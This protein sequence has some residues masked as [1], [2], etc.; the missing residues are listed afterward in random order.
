MKYRIESDALGDIRVPED[1][2]YGAQTQRAVENFRISGLKLQDDFIKALAIIKKN[3]A[4]ANLELG[5]IEKQVAELIVAAAD[6]VMEGRHDDQFVV[7]VFQTGSGTSTNMNMNE[8]IAGRANEIHTGKKGSKEPVHPNDH[9][10]LCQSSNDVIPS[11]IN[12]AVLLLIENR[13]EPALMKLFRSLSSKAG[14]FASIRKLGRTHLQDAVVMTLGQEFSGYTAQIKKNI[15]RLSE[16][17]KEL[18]ELSLG[19]TAVGTGINAHPDF[20]AR[21]IAM[22]ADQTGIEFREAG[23][24][25]ASQASQDGSVAI[26]GV[27]NTVGV[28]LTKIANDIRWL[29][30]GPRAGL[31]EIN[32]PAVQPGSSILPGKINPVIPEAVLQVAAQLTGNDATITAAAKGGNFELNTMLPVIAYKLIQ[33]VDILAN[34]SLVFAE[35]CIDGITANEE[36]CKSNV[37]NSLD[38]A[39]KL[40]PYI[41]YDRASEIAKTAYREGKTVRQVV[42]EKGVLNQEQMREVFQSQP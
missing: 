13:L 5:L 40:I 15:E 22:I 30:S 7:D 42:E 8:V 1:A 34:A 11:A 16:I 9:V 18:L 38:A 3:A 29:S 25:F 17:K 21:L 19:G 26:S 32:L 10:N 37:E 14:E 35:K 28:S 6:E 24:H 4:I 27:L 36:K 23:N 2:L 39:V 33:S 12:I 20:A 31:G 41:G